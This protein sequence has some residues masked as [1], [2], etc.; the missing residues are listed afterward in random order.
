MSRL[1]IFLGPALAPF[2]V[3]LILLAA[4]PLVN[5]IRRLPDGRIKRVLLWR[6]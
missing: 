5:R 6:Y 2:F 1:E 3:L 4:R